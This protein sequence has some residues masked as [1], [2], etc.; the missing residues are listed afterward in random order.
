MH[1]LINLHFYWSFV[2]GKIL[3]IRLGKISKI[4]LL[5]KF[6][7]NHSPNLK[8]KKKKKKRKEKKRK[9]KKRKEKKRKEKKRKEKKRKTK[10]LLKPCGKYSIIH[11][12][13]CVVWSVL[14]IRSDAYLTRVVRFSLC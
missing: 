7:C 9:E 6:E 2:T 11:I 5:G 12:S 13:V 4:F 14:I 1:G 3:V 10:E 8:K